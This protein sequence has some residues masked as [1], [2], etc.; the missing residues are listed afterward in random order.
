M[1]GNLA[2]LIG[3]IVQHLDLEKLPRIVQFAHGTEQTL[4]HVNL[5]K[6]WQLHCHFWQSFKITSWDRCALPVFE[7]QIDDEVAMD[8]VRR[9]AD[10]HTQITDGPDNVSEASLHGSFRGCRW[11]EASD[12]LSGPSVI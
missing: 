1:G 5:V 7:I 10:E 12:T 8:T 3:R 9:E 4:S 6:D 2:G 11:K